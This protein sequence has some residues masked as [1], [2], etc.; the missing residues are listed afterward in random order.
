MK[1]IWDRTQEEDSSYKTMYLYMCKKSNRGVVFVIF[2]LGF[3]N[4]LESSVL[5][6]SSSV[7]LAQS[8]AQ[9][10]SLECSQSFVFS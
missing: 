7:F 2:A 10:K 6:E 8:L 9:M 4:V 3:L 5:L 1:V